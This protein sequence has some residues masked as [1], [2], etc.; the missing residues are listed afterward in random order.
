MIFIL[1]P[2]SGRVFHLCVGYR[3]MREMT[4]TTKPGLSSYRIVALD[5]RARWIVGASWSTP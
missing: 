3:Q 1:H 4:R 5:D 2:P